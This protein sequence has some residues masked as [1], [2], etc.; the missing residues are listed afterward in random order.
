MF[1]SYLTNF[2]LL[3]NQSYSIWCLMSGHHCRLHA[4]VYKYQNSF[5]LS[6]HNGL[7]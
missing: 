7:R 2:Q 4:K 5:Q 3:F 1:I 6:K